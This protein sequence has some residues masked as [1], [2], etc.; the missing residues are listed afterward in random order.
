MTGPV[1]G[2]MYEEENTG[3]WFAV[4][5]DESTGELRWVFVQRRYSWPVPSPDSL[6]KHFTEIGGEE[7]P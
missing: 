6:R 4:V 3:R 7:T 1:A 5:P 2:Q